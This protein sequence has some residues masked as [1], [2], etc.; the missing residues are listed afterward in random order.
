MRSP[1]AVLSSSGGGIFST[2][3]TVVTSTAGCSSNSTS[4]LSPACSATSGASAGRKPSRS[5]R[6]LYGATGSSVK[7]NRPASSQAA[8]RL[9]AVARFVT[10]IV[11]PRTTSPVPDR[12][13]PAITPVV[14]ATPPAVPKL[15]SKAVR[16]QNP[17]RIRSLPASAV[18][19]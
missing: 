18:I 7:T 14:E 17:A 3:V 8:R 4:T 11:A 6:T 9:P 16:I 13:V 2:T 10:D 12:T 5:A 19:G 1:E 15:H